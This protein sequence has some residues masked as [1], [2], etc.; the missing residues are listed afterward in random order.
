MNTWLSKPKPKLATY[1]NATAPVFN[2]EPIDTTKS[3]QIDYVL[4]N[5][6]WRNAIIN[7]ES[8][9]HTIMNSHHAALLI[10][11]IK[12]KLATKKKCKIPTNIK[13]SRIQ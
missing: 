11:T 2:L 3:A 8:V 1:R 4:V 10:A 9:H 5:S 13:Y 6:A 7:I 12:V